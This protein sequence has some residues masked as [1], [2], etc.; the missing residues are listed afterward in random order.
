MERGHYFFK[1]LP[2]PPLLFL[3]TALIHILVFSFISLNSLRL[4]SL[5]FIVF[6]FCLFNWVISNDLSLNMLFFLLLDQQLCRTPALNFSV[7]LL[8]SSGFPDGSVVKNLPAH[9]GDVDS[10]PGL[11]RSPGEGKA[12]H[13]SILT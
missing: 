8:R 13:S 11:G 10:I 6:S 4:S 5:F 3:G 2:F 9:V 1:F 12:T 7:Q